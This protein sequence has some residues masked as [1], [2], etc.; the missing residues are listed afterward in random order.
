MSMKC[1]I[2]GCGRWGAIVAKKMCNL[3]DRIVLVD[4]DVLRAQRVADELRRWYPTH[5]IT[6]SGDPEGYLAVS[7]TQ[8]NSTLGGVVIIATPPESHRK[9]FGWVMGGYGRPPVAV[10]VEKPLADAYFRMLVM[11]EL[12]DANDTLLSVG[13]TLLHDPLYEYVFDKIRNRALT[14]KAVHADRVG[15]KRHNVDA[16]LDLGVHAAYVAAYVLPRE[17]MDD[18]VSIEAAYAS[19]DAHRITKIKVVGTSFTT[20]T[21]N[22][23]ART[24]H[25]A[26]PHGQQRDVVKTF[27]ECD[28][29]MRELTAFWYN[30]HRAT[31]RSSDSFVFDAESYA[32]KQILTSGAQYA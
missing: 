25:I 19:G 1:T 23:I 32:H 22:E 4:T 27:S 8:S 2:I 26:D 31:I 5:S 29:L 6:S 13:A 28:V 18:S 24:V 30:R 21:V 15:M 7:G 9:V 12:A 17:C 20:F 10:R 3:T 14:V 16:M 11:S